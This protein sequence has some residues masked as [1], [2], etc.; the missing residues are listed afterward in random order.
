MLASSHRHFRP[1]GVQ[2]NEYQALPK[3]RKAFVAAI[4]AATANALMRPSG[5]G[6]PRDFCCKVQL[7]I[8]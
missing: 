8:A 4:F 7:P 2:Y 1:F 3:P 5:H 6:T